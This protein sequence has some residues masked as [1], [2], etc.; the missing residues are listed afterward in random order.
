MKIM[1]PVKTMKKTSKTRAQA[2]TRTVFFMSFT[3][4]MFFM[5]AAVDAQAVIDRTLSVPVAGQVILESDIRQARLLHLVKTDLGNNDAIQMELENR[6]LILAELSRS[7]PPEPSAE[8]KA[9]RRRT[10][11]ASFDPGVNIAERIKQ[12][13]MTDAG[14]DA[15]LSDDV[16]V[17]KYIRQRFGSVGDPAAAIERWLQGLRKRAGLPARLRA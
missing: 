13:G 2:L 12:S 4:F 9:A 10:W 14:L 7:R 3:G 1:K 11:E 16:K 6:L 8:E 5:I 15:W 17:E